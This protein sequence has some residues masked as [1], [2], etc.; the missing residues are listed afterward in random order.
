M[1]PISKTAY[2]TLSV[3]AWD[4]TLAKPACGDNYASVFMNEE[5]TGVWAEFKN[6]KGPNASNASRHAIIDNQLRDVLNSKPDSLVIIIGAGFDTRAFRLQGGH[7]V[8]VDEPAII[9]YKESK[10][11]ASEASNS[12]TRIPIS[13]SSESLAE[14][15]AAFRTREKTHFVIEG[16]LMYLNESQRA[17]LLDI[18]YQNFPSHVVYCDLMRKS[19]FE[20]YGRKLHEKI[21]SLGASFTDISER[22]EELFLNRG[23][24]ILSHTS[25]SLYAAEH[26]NLGAPPFLLR[27]FFR[28][29]REGYAIWRFSKHG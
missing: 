6:Q 26:G 7:W 8:E 24:E 12:L 27:Y 25:I 9:T 13:F 1:N 11:P 23:Y 22:P 20:S 19:F 17:N 3:R 14:K 5:A 28:K 29:L 21:V 4:A 10:L 15:L 2:Y 16:V 18:L